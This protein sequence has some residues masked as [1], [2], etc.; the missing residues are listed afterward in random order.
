MPPYRGIVYITVG[1]YH[2]T[3]ELSI[4]KPGTYEISLGYDAIPYRL[5]DSTSTVY[6]G[7]GGLQSAPSSWT[8]AAKRP[9]AAALTSP[10]SKRCISERS[11]TPLAW[12]A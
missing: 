5:F 8:P 11:K 4:A 2:V 3:V 10:V 7:S 12:V 1:G 6:S 9:C